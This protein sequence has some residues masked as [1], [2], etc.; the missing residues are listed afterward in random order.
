MLK[1]WVDADACPTVIRDIIFRAAIRTGIETFLVANQTINTPAH[2]HIRSIQVPGGF[3][4]ADDEIVR[5][6]SSGDVV[7]TQDIPLAAEVLEKGAKAIS[8]RGEVFSP[9]TIKAKLGMRD[10]METLR[11]SG[12]QTGG[13]KAMNQNDR[14]TFADA[15]DRI[16]TR[17][18]RA[19]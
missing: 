7:I 2:A 9:N 10:F 19:G 17:G 15:L 1:I 11:A 8:P 3:D 4:A 12:V 14:K 18:I 5:R 13:P 6:V 16:L